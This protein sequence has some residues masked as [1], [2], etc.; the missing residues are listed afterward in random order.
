MWRLRLKLPETSHALGYERQGSWDHA[1]HLYEEAIV[2]S[3]T[4]RLL[5]FRASFSYLA[6]V[7]DAKD[8]EC[9][10]WESQW[11]KCARELGQFDSVL[12]I[13]EEMKNFDVISE[14]VC[15]FVV[16]VIYVWQGLEIAKLEETQRCIDKAGR[17]ARSNLPS[18]HWP[19]HVSD[20][21][22]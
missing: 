18:A 15:F 12:K 19:V 14:A 20:H 13:G 21:R 2:V 22:R 7:L 17:P 9:R 3:T 4:K 8:G 10:L 11:I 1:Q 6:A 5:L 16:A